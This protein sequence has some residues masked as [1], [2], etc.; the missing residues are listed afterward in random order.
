MTKVERAI[1][2][3][4]SPCVP[5]SRH[6][7]IQLTEVFRRSCRGVHEARE[8]QRNSVP[9]CHS[10]FIFLCPADC[11]TI[12]PNITQPEARKCVCPA[13]KS[14]REAN[15]SSLPAAY[16]LELAGT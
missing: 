1:F 14:S 13:G 12:L 11:F 16:P 3:A 7:T 5:P 10:L 4:F 15:E 9:A 2:V 8:K 6:L